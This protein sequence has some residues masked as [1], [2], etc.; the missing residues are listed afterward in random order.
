MN[1][2]ELTKLIKKQDQHPSRL[3]EI[4]ASSGFEQGL[5]F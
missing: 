3:I 4:Y 1:F 5:L 2:G